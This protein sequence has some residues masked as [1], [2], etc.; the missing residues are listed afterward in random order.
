MTIRTKAELKQYISDTFL[1]DAKVPAALSNTKI[2]ASEHK[3]FLNDLVDS[4][5]IGV[6][7]ETV[8][9]DNNVIT[10]TKTDSSTE[11][12]N[13]PNSIA[14]VT[15]DTSAGTATFTFQDNNTVAIQTISDDEETIL[16]TIRGFEDTDNDG[17]YLA[18]NSAGNLVLVDS[19]QTGSIDAVRELSLLDNIITVTKTDSSTETLN[20][21]D[22]I[23]SVT[24]NATSGEATFTFNGTSSD[25]TIQTISDAEENILSTINGFLSTA[26]D[27]KILSIDSNGQLVLIDAPSIPE[28]P[29]PPADSSHTAYIYWWDTQTY[30]SAV[31]PTGLPSGTTVVSG[32]ANNVQTVTVSENIG[33]DYLVI[34]QPSAANDLTSVII[35]G[36]NQLD[37]FTK[38]AVQTISGTEYEIYITDN[39]LLG[40]SIGGET[41]EIRRS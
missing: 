21:P 12:I 23:A 14:G 26:N 1:P 16:T 11:T 2:N 36:L 31:P 35:D 17:K 19:T 29:T 33:N 10:I 8:T 39:R 13:L 22:S 27:G 7:I 34:L 6:G 15:Q 25:V 28:P 30:P 20:L 40:P 24:Q 37:A 41:I 3:T 4:I 18:I 32:P 38:Y 5:E 9:I